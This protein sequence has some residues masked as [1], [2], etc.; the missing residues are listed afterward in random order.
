MEPEPATEPATAPAAATAAATSAEPPSKRCGP[1]FDGRVCNGQTGSIYCEEGSG[2]CVETT[3][4]EN[5]GAFSMFDFSFYGRCGPLYQGRVCNPDAGAEWELYCNEQTGWCSNTM[6]DAKMLTTPY[7]AKDKLAEAPV[8]DPAV[9]EEG[10]SNSS[11]TPSLT[12]EQAK[13]EVKAPAVDQQQAFEAAIKKA[14]ERSPLPIK[15]RR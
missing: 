2:W 7:D 11:L 9:H 6:Q 12:E 8:V 13:P 4:R 15:H 3:S 10:W 1:N 14:F 5:D